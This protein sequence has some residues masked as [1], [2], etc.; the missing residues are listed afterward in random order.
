[1][2]AQDRGP[3]RW[4][5]HVDWDDWHWQLANRITGIQELR[6][7]INLTPEEE[8]GVRRCLETLRIAITP[9]YASLMDPDDPACPIRKQAVPMAAELQFGMAESEDPLQEDVDSPVPGVTHRYPDRVLLLVT[10]QC[11]MY[12]RH[13][14][15]RRLAGKTDRP[16]PQERIEAALAYI[17]KTPDI[18]DVLLS[19]GDSLLLSEDRLGDILERLRAMEHV[20]II[21]IGTRAPVV[22]P[23][24]ITPALCDLLRRFHPLYVNTHFNHPKEITPE[25]TEACGR[26]AD[27]GLPLGNQTVL[28]RGVNDCPYIIKD[29]VHALLRMRV[30]PYYLYQCD[31]SPGLEHFRTTVAQ[32]IEIIE[33]LRGHTSGLA[34]P[35][36]VVDAPGGGGKI[37]VAP[38]Y[39]ISQSERRVILRNYE[40]VISAYTEP[41]ERDGTC[42]D[43]PTCERLAYRGGAGLEKLLLGAELSL[44]PQD[45]ER[46]QRRH[47]YC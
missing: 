12:C 21:R 39:L 9:Y 4:V 47:T 42:R 6:V 31:L 14:T 8:Q 25:A 5:P 17:R 38:Q 24:R 3:W 27:A 13:C 11:A 1:M 34:V 45:T 16:L 43:C 20:E 33:L 18:R 15:R 40:G 37:P 22:V 41:A 2:S 28:L 32:G 29:L 7:L 23:Q 35:T 36:Y 44:I 10:D 30:R 46:E 19:G 26:L